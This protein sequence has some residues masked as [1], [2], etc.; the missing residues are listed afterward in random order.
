M[1][2]GK[3]NKPALIEHFYSPLIRQRFI[4]APP[5]H[6]SA[7]ANTPCHLKYERRLAPFIRGYVLR[8][9]P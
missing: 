4:Q 8:A 9:V 3:K 6:M 1:H 7:V 2:S 5:H